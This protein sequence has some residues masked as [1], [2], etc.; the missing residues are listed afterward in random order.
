M[1][2]LFCSNAEWAATGYGVE[3]KYLIPGLEKLGH[4]VGVFPFWGLQGGL[5]EYQGRPNYPVLQDQWGNDAFNHH[6]QHFKADVVIT[7]MDTWVLDPDYA[8]KVR[9]IPWVPID[10]APIPPQVLERTRGALR[11]VAFS[12]FGQKMYKDAGVEVDYIPH[13]IDTDNFKP[14][15]NRAELKQKLGFPPNCFLIGMVAANKGWPCRKCFPEIFEAFSEFVKRHPGAYLYVHSEPRNIYNGPD[16]QNMAATYGISNHMRFPNPYLLSL[17][18]PPELLNE[19]YNAMDV[20]CGVS[21]GEGFGIP[22]VE[23]QAAGIPVIVTDFASS[24][25]LCAAGWK[26]KPSRK[27]W[28]PLNSFQ[29]LP[30]IDGIIGA[31]EQAYKAD[32][33]EMGKTARMFALDYRW[34]KVIEAWGGLLNKVEP[35]V[36]NHNVEVT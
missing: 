15:S 24:T 16:L 7:L 25:E 17:G 3:A 4:K 34:E 2:I 20:Y 8:K 11:I 23:A 28:T 6:A 1:R 10:H 35:F 31:M 5:I 19:I 21:M 30:N 33:V 18:F 36:Y 32:R 13:G 29:A 22:T 9:W 26:V 14:L 27:W 12:K